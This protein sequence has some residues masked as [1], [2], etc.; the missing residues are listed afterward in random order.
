[1]PNSQIGGA[2]IA[3]APEMIGVGTNEPIK[4]VLPVQKQTSI[5]WE[6]ALLQAT[7]AAAAG[8]I[9]TPLLQCS[10]K[11]TIPGLTVSQVIALT[12]KRKCSD[13]NERDRMCYSRSPV[14]FR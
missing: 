2:G 3:D 10:N 13:K 7:C 14:N 8:C 1:M 12:R 5:R 9:A 4:S 6:S 11:S